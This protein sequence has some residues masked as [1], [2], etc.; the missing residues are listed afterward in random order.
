MSEKLVVPSIS[1]SGFNHISS[2]G[3]HL[4]GEDHEVNL[5]A[6]TS[7][8]LGL[9]E[10]GTSLTESE[11]W[12]VLRRLHFDT[13][14]SL[15]DLPPSA[16]FIFEKIEQMAPEEAVEILK[17]AIEEHGADVNIPD[18]DLQLWKEL[19][20]FHGSK[21]VHLGTPDHSSDG[22]SITGKDVKYHVH[23]KGAEDSL[24][25]PNRHEIVDWTLQ[26]R[27]E[28]VLV[29]YWSPYPEVRAVTF[30]FDD[31]TIPVE[32]FRVYLIGIIWTGI[33]AVINQFFAERQPSISL[34]M[35]VVQVFLYPSGLLCEW[36]LPNWS[37]TIWK[38]R[39]DL[40]P[41]P[42]TFKEQMLAT[43]FC[44]VSGGS[45]SYVSS[46]ILMQKSELFYDNKWVD[47]GYQVLLILSTNFLG[48]GLSGIMRK[49]AVYPVKAVWPSILPGIALNKT[50]LSPAKK[51]V[52]NGWKI[53]AYKFFFITFWASFAYFWVPDYLFQALSYF[54]WMTWIKPDNLNLAVITGSLGGLGLNPIPTFDWN[55]FSSMLQ[56]LQVPFY[57]PVNNIIGM[58][59][60]FFCIIGVWYSN[61]KWT[62]Y[63]PINDNGLY[64]NTG[65]PYS[66][67]AVVNEKSL[68]DVDKYNEI[69]PP[70]YTAANLVV[71]G[72][73]FA[74]Y[75]FHIVYEIGMNYR[76]MWDACKSFW[77][78]FRN[79]RNS[80]YDGFDD[81][82]SIMM[83]NNYKEVPEWAYLIIVVI[84]LVLAILCVKVY[85]AETPVWGIFFALGINFVFLI[86]LTTVYARTGFSF[87][88]NVLV[89]LIVGYAIPGNGLA[90]AFIKALGYNIDGQ[91]QNF[92]NDLKSGHYAKLPPRAVYRVQLL[93]IFIASFIQLGIL[94]FQI[95]G[96]IAN[97]C[98]PKNTQKFTC[99]GTRTFYSAS[100]LWGVIGPKKV[101]N[102]LYPILQWCFLIGFLAAIPCIIIKRWGPRNYVKYFEPSIIIGGFLGYAPYNLTYYLPGLYVSYVFMSYIRRKYEA[103]WQKYNYILST[104]LNAGIAFSS[105]IIFFAVMYHEKDIN[106]WGNTVSYSGIDLSMTGWLDASVDAPDGYFGP[107]VGDFP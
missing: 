73:F 20:D 30:P 95:D 98:D 103:W 79:W 45:T 23:E 66:V 83:R 9:A 107:R 74:L 64:T 8:P 91:A 49:F 56:P 12:F 40:N 60:G 54:N 99:P 14:M 69:G 24:T 10:V 67:T 47:F 36:I 46:N 28:S 71:Y 7:N 48:I 65:E 59:F 15:D 25:D 68:F 5:D 82:H 2:I 88:L 106:W 51:E 93:S 32:T 96:G 53:S 11:K 27:L 72:A 44:G 38:W 84:S 75:P 21:E 76:E 78:L 61:Y 63:L 26:V 16:T 102:G 33:G 81:P 37:F 42:Y 35:S 77:R 39:I 57:N 70:F 97:Y 1:P 85:P 50:L 55:Y 41:G 3:S 90:L 87:G 86:P 4:Q 105:I 89:E 29:A 31:P 62:G 101:F 43:I 18:Q 17:K 19:V 52:I 13:L 34:A 100:V 92:I 80:T 22:G 94:N 104:G 6:M 58:M